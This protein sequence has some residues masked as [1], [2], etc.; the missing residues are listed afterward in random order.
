LDIKIWAHFRRS[1]PET[2]L[3]GAMA[4]PLRAVSLR[5]AQTPTIPLRES[6][7]KRVDIFD[8]TGIFL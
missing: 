4:T 2:G 1:A 6:T 5:F 3:F 8:E 7:R